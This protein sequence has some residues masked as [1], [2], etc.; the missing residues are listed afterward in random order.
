M[1]D[2]RSRIL[3]VCVPIALAAIGLTAAARAD[4]AKSSDDE[5]KD[6]TAIDQRVDDVDQRLKIM[7]RKQEIAQED[8]DKKA[9]D[10][11]SAGANKD[12]FVFKSA[13]GSFKLRVRGLV[14][15]DARFWRDDEVKP[16][17]D[18]FLVRRARPILEGTV[19]KYFDF[20]LM[21]DF[22]AGTTSLQDAWVEAKLGKAPLKVRVG[23]F[24]EPFGLARL[25]SDPDTLF[26]EL[27]LPSNLVPN[28]DEGI[29]LSGDHLEGVFTWQ[30]AVVNGVADGGSTD[31][32]TDD[33]KDVAVRVFAQ[34]FKKTGIMALRGL[35]IGAAATSGKRIGTLTAPGVATYRTP[36][37]IGF[38]SYRTGTTL[39]LTVVGDGDLERFSP[40]I[41]W[42]WKRF[43]F[44]GEHVTS[45]QEV[46]LDTTSA[47][48]EHQ[49]WQAE[50]SFLLTP[51]TSSFATITPKKGVGAPDSPGKGAVQLAVRYA[52]L[53]LD[54]DTFPTF[55]SDTSQA[56]K[57]RSTGIGVNWILNRFFKVMLDV[58]E[59]KFD[60]GAV[61][62]DRETERVLINRVQIYF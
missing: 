20:R 10:A 43:G 17:V 12:G 1:R 45:S 52:E 3:Y 19:Y 28:R 47:K 57:A 4:E 22:G 30:V 33:S 2:I 40:Q 48:L 51:D 55:A 58:E 21:P 7:E 37:Q 8:A 36:G 56:R 13:D 31:A 42:Y 46:T 6:D 35:G 61:T 60:G 25:Q 44:M 59:T 39:P 23:K 53:K 49:A 62:G 54:S 41:Y 5:K 15:G 38:F 14:Q 24:K 29:Q 11:A 34:P 50:A 32:D 9:K 18:T 27:A 16:A 26:T